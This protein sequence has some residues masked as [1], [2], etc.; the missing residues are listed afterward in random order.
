MGSLPAET[1]APT[2]VEHGD[3]SSR[4]GQARHGRVAP[5][6]VHGIFKFFRVVDPI[7]SRLPISSES[8]SNVPFTQTGFI[9]AHAPVYDTGALN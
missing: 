7:I 8:M 5:C 2:F 9:T 1:P 3:T 4:L 6:D